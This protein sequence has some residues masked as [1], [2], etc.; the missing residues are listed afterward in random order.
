MK[1]SYAYS[2]GFLLSA[3]F[4][5]L[6]TGAASAQS[7]NR[8]DP[9]QEKPIARI[10]TI[11]AKLSVRAFDANGKR[12]TDLT[13]RDIV[14][15]ENGAGRQV[16][17]LKLEPTNILVVLDQSSEFGPLKS[18]RQTTIPQPAKGPGSYRPIATPA[19]LEFIERLTLGLGPKDHLAILQYSDAIEL[20]QSWT[21]SREQAAQAIIGRFR[22]GRKARYFDALKAAAD[23][24]EKAPAGKKAM[25]LVTDGVDT[26]S[27][28]SELKAVEELRKTGAT[29][30]VVSFARFIQQ[31]RGTKKSKQNQDYGAAPRETPHDQTGGTL[32]QTP[33]STGSYDISGLIFGRKQAKAYKEYL[34]KVEM[35]A[36]GLGR[37][38]DETGGDDYTPRDVDEL[39]LDSGRIL[40]EIGSQYTL[41]YLTEKRDNGPELRKIEALGAR[42]GLSIQ[43][44]RSTYVRQ[45]EGALK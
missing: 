45:P 13:P 4:L 35:A 41:T 40:E 10:E 22:M 15:I 27:D 2:S 33:S 37:L 31:E 19:G 39:L 42:P 23:V 20:V 30:F 3:M 43:T 12:V 44:R 25:I 36:V 26:A 38:A 16:T 17:S 34:Q 5:L 14:L 28:S 24:F 18:G 11:E 32:R 29:I 6:M 1:A 8:P 21:S 9:E 7:G